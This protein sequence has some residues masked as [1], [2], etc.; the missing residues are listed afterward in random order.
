MLL[1]NKKNI[2]FYYKNNKTFKLFYTLKSV[3]R[4]NIALLYTT[5]IAPRSSELNLKQI[6]IILGKL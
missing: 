5:K 1:R 2:F 3:Y 6:F 4:K